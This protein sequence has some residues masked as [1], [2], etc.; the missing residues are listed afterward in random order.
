MAVAV[1]VDLCDFCGDD[2]RAARMNL[3]YAEIDAL[4]L[5]RGPARPPRNNRQ[6]PEEANT[7]S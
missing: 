1:R 5:T 3:V 4:A 2:V 6:V 7:G